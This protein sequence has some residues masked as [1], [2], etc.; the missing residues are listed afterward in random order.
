MT[1]YGGAN[2]KGAIFSI[3]VS[4]GAPTTLA[5]FNGTNGS[6]PFGSLILSGST[7]YGMTFNG[8]VYDEGTVF[9]IPITGGSVTTMVSFN[10]T[11]GQFRPAV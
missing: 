3:P 9:S 5:S 7:L 8:G 1:A 4:G 2:N 6:I 11:N 10:G